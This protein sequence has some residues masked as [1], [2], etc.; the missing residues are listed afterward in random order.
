M[1]DSQRYATAL[2]IKLYVY[3]EKFTRILE[4]ST[5]VMDKIMEDF[6]N[7]P[8]KDDTVKNE[9][10]RRALAMKIQN[11]GQLFRAAGVEVE[12]HQ[13]SEWRAIYGISDSLSVELFFSMLNEFGSL[14]NFSFNY[15][16]NIAL[17]RFLLK[18]STTEQV[19]R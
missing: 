13:W 7:A 10:V 18:L 19:G 17:K 8:M 2:P 1:D 9:M 16:Q 14:Q 3:F 11:L 5:C 6:R 12:H 4:K 15:C